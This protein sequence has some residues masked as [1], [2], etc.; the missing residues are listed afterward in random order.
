MVVTSLSS[1]RRQCATQ[2]HIYTRNDGMINPRDC[3]RTL[4]W[5]KCTTQLMTRFLIFQKYF[6]VCGDI[7]GQFYD[8]MELF[9]TGGEVPDTSYVFMGDYVD[10]GYHSVETFELLMCLKAR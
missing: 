8:L 9:R 4:S 2:M 3:L 10:R 1:D 5:S 6:Q 7:H